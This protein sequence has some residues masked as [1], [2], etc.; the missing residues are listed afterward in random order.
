MKINN[1]QKLIN[2]M[3]DSY[4]TQKFYKQYFRKKYYN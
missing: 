2:F 3:F 1:N 4:D